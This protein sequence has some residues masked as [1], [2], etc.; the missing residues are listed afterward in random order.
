MINLI[1]CGIGETAD[2]AYEY[3]THDSNYKVI[4]YAVNKQFISKK[5]HNNLP[6]HAIEELLNKFSPNNIEV[7]IAISYTKL[8]RVR[9]NIFNQ[10]KSLGFKCASYVSSAAFVWKTAKIGENCFIFENNVIQHNVEI[11]DNIIIWSGNHIGH[12]SVIQDHAYI[13]S[14][15]VISGFCNVGKQ[16]FLGVNCTVNDHISI[17]EDT[18]IGSGSIINKNTIKGTVM[19]SSPATKFTRSSYKTFKVNEDEI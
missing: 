19:I 9:R 12:Q 1:I 13:S 2:L 17:A 4:G 18:I 6:L 11:G 10:V 3:F 5:E 16:A 15:C 7:F 8:N 14:H